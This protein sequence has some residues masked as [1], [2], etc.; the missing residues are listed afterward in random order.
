MDKFKHLFPDEESQGEEESSHPEN[1][2]LDIERVDTS[3]MRSR[4]PDVSPAKTNH[5]YVQS[6]EE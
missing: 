5:V 6:S 4:S 3:P 2:K 1:I